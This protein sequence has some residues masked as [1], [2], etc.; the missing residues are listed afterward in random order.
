MIRSALVIGGGIAGP[1]AAM[2]LQKAGIDAVVYEAYPSAADGAGGGLT[3]APNG[4]DAL[5]VIGFGDL[6]RPAFPRPA[7][8]CRTGRASG[9]GSSATRPAC[10]RCSSST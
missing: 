10:R 8:S 4:L 9:W 1:V 6:V 7:S 5:D 3:L 2:A